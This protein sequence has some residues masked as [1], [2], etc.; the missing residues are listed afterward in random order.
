MTSPECKAKRIPLT[1]ACG[2]PAIPF[3]RSTGWLESA[4]SDTFLSVLANVKGSSGGRIIC[5]TS[6]KS[7][8]R[9]ARLQ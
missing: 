3:A 2:F 4:A 5:C 8:P 6:T 1:L 9:H 7:C